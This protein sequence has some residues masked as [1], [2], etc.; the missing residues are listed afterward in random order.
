M[1]RR[2]AR[3]P[4]RALKVATN[5]LAL[6]AYFRLALEILEAARA[7]GQQAEARPF[8]AGEVTAPDRTAHVAAEAVRTDTGGALGTLAAV[9]RRCSLREATIERVSDR[10]RQIGDG[11]RTIA[12]RVC[13]WTSSGGFGADRDAHGPD[14][15]ADR[16]LTV[17]IAVA[18][19]CTR[20]IAGAS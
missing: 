14:E 20:A 2:K 3:G 8:E 13:R 18:R 17:G 19:A 11:H 4:V 12:I 15:L 9:A 1:P 6:V 16:D 5:L 7:Q 10:A